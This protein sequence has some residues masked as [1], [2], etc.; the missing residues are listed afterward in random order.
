MSQKKC[1]LITVSLFLS[2]S[3]FA[4]VLIKDISFQEALQQAKAADKIVLLLIESAECNQCN[5]VA[6]QGFSNQILGRSVNTS[7]ITVKVSPGSKN[8]GTVD[9]LFTIGSSFG[10]LFINAEGDLLHRYS[11]SSS[12]YITYMEQLDK[13]LN[14]KEHPDAEFKQLQNEY[15]NGKRDF[16]LLYKLVAKKNEWDFEHDQLTEEM[17]TVAP[18]DSSASLTFLQFIAV[19]APVIDSKAFQYMRKDNRNFNDAWFLMN[20]QKRIAANNKIIFKS[21]S[22]AIKEKNSSYAEKVANFSAGIQTDRTQSRKSHDR[23]MIDFYK[24]ISDTSSFLLASVKYYDQYLMTIRVDSVQRVDSMRR[25]D[26]FAYAVPDRVTQASG[27]KVLMRSSP[28]APMTQNFT[29]ELN[30]GAWT[31]YIYTHDLFYMAKAL[32]WAKRATE[33]YENPAAI[34]TYARLLYRTGNREE[35]VNWEEKA[36]QLTKTRRMPAS[37]FEEVIS[38][39]KSGINTIDKY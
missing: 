39:M 4:Q 12:Y 32:S 36:I 37:E 17:V 29:N 34:D 13:A 18:N 21:K 35:A 30:D 20:L 5:E 1:I 28:Y 2:A 14:R 19:Q 10:L 31:I 6:M 24:G 16:E 38:K 33:F 23:N 3:L 8:F 26:M 22:K 7:C 25:R 15:T 9:S 11:A 27:S